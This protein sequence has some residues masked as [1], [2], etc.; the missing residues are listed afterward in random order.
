M[1]SV[2]VGDKYTFILTCSLYRVILYVV[3]VWCVSILYIQQQRSLTLTINKF[4]YGIFRLATNFPENTMIID[5]EEGTSTYRVSFDNVR[6]YAD[7]DCMSSLIAFFRSFLSAIV[8]CSGMICCK[9]SSN[10]CCES[11]CSGN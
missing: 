6:V 8:A 2:S 7:S 10:S 4:K 1:L 9:T 3:L 5:Y 11:L